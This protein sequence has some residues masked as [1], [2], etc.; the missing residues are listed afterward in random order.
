MSGVSADQPDPGIQ[1]AHSD[2]AAAMSGGD[3]F[4]A[5]VNAISSLR[6]N[7][8]RQAA[9]I[10]DSA[11][12]TL[13]EA[14]KA[15]EAAMGALSDAKAEARE[16]VAK[17]RQEAA[18][19]LLEASQQVADLRAQGQDLISKAKQE[20]AGLVAEAK[21]LKE[22]IAERERELREHIA[23]AEASG[24][25]HVEA[26]DRYGLAAT[27]HRNA[28]KAYLEVLDTLESAMSRAQQII[29]RVKT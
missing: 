12:K 17:A 11:N 27:D 14:S 26:R 28:E 19:A 6:E 16:I 21:A 29:S 23:G 13:S 24:R 25:E 15:R 7:A 1:E 8:K 20:A 10:I 4:L 2:L 22:S 5:R 18:Q 9:A 3:N